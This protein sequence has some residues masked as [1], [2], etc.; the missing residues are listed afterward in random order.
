MWSKIKQ[1]WKHFVAVTMA[2]IAGWFGYVEAQTRTVTYTW[3]NPVTR[4]DGSPFTAAMSAGTDI[5]WGLV[6]G[7]PYVNTLTA[8]AGATSAVLNLPTTISCGVVYAV[9]VA[10]AVDGSRSAPTNEVSRDLGAC[11]PNSPTNFAAS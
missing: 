4:T 3:V 5:Q 11:P 9:G 7:G 8:P 1:K 10:K 6:K 2:I